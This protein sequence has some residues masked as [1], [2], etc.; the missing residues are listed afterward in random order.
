MFLTNP[1]KS[2]QHKI[3]EDYQENLRYHLISVKFNFNNFK[4]MNHQ[5]KIIENKVKIK[6]KSRVLKSYL[7]NL[8]NF[9]IKK[10]KKKS[11]KVKKV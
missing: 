4:A 8:I 3:K 11:N 6:I 7:N 10:V 9:Q 1:P 2:H 5:I